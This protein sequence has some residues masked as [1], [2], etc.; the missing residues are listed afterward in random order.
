MPLPFIAYQAATR[1]V[2]SALLHHICVIATK[3]GAGAQD[4]ISKLILIFQNSILGESYVTDRS[5][6][7]AQEEPR[8]Q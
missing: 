5:F 4:K 8:C 2:C 3:A 1:F 7:S 6:H